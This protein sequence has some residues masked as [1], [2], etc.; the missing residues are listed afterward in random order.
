METLTLR[1]RIQLAC[2]L[3]TER[4]RQN[5]RDYLRVTDYG[6]RYVSPEAQYELVK[7]GELTAPDEWDWSAV[8]PRER[9]PA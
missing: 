2:Q 1:F 7:R 4:Q 9:R 3:L 5:L 6:R 8:L